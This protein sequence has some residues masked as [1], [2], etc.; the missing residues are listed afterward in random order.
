MKIICIDL[1]SNSFRVLKFDCNKLK[2]IGTYHKITGL[3]NNLITTK[4]IG[5]EAA[6]KVIVAILES[7]EK[8]DYHN[9]DKI[10]AYTTAAMRQAKNSE[11]IL[12][13]IYQ[14]TGIKFKIIDGNFEA[15]LTLNAVKFALKRH[16]YEND[17]FLALDI[18]GGSTEIVINQKQNYFSKSFDFGIITLGQKF[19]NNLIGLDSFL[20]DKKKDIANSIYN[21]SVNLDKCLFIGTAGTPTTVA[22]IKHNCDYYSY[23]K[24]IINGTVITKSDLSKCLK[25]L[26]NSTNKEL[27]KIIGKG[28]AHFVRVGI[29]IY[30]MIFEVINKEESLVFDDG[31]REGMAIN[32]SIENNFLNKI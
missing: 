21:N 7:K 26:D 23:N 22:A 9:N 19:T 30:K 11:T 31:L 27:E 16:L 13:Y 20:N 32:Y 1:G 3:A 12:N 10:I 8:I 4:E 28:R 18:G 14:K 6:N 29:M 2:P 15:K 24:N 5:L 25:I 17:N